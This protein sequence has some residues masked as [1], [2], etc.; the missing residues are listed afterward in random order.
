MSLGIGKIS[1]TEMLGVLS[2]KR[3]EH[4]RG[5]VDLSL[6]LQ[7]KEIRLGFGKLYLVE[8]EHFI[9]EFV[10]DVDESILL[11]F[12]RIIKKD[13]YINKF[14]KNNGLFK[15]DKLTEIYDLINS[16]VESDFKKLNKVLYL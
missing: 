15:L 6:D 10:S 11:E 13:L 14:F 1:K 7:K 5:R 9:I 2:R 8:A 12:D 4:I 3:S 16:A